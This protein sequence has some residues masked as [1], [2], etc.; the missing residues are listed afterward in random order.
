MFRQGISQ[1]PVAWSS[2]PADI[3]WVDFRGAD[4][5]GKN[6]GAIGRDIDL[7]TLLK[8]IHHTPKIF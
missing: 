2:W 7:S 5:A 8:R 1:T 4:V 3:Q 6:R